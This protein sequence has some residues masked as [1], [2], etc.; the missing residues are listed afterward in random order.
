MQA[1][2]RRVRLE[3]QGLENIRRKLE[4]DLVQ[5]NGQLKEMGMETGKENE[6]ERLREKVE[7]L[8]RSLSLGEVKL[9]S[10]EKE[11]GYLKSQV[12]ERQRQIDDL[13]K[14]LGRAGNELQVVK[15]EKERLFVRCGELEDELRQNLGVIEGL[16]CSSSE[17]VGDVRMENV[18][19]EN[20]R[21]LSELRVM[22]GNLK[23]AENE[24]GMFRSESFVVK[25]VGAKKFGGSESMVYR[26]DEQQ[27]ERVEENA[28]LKVSL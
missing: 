17:V 8:S 10:A 2:A 3:L 14:E 16:R 12:D 18:E 11:Y 19:K 7:V 21:L 5:M 23:R 28:V 13:R 25:D 4:G 15:R 26:E 27:Q 6:I 9:V 22:S 20:R 24:L 1:D